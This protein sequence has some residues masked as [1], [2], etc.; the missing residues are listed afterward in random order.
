MIEVFYYPQCP[1]VAPVLLN[2]RDIARELGVDYRERDLFR[3][4]L[5][6]CRTSLLVAVD[7]RAV[8]IVVGT[9]DREYTKSVVEAALHGASVSRPA[10]AEDE[11]VSK[12]KRDSGETLKLLEAVAIGSSTIDDV[13]DLCISEDFIYGSLAEGY[14]DAAKKM[15][16]EWLERA[17]QR[18]GFAGMI[19]Y[20][21][22]RAV[23]FIEA[24]PGGISEN[25]GMTMAHHPEKTWE[26]LC[27][28]VMRRYWRA[29]VASLLVEKAM[30]HLKE[31]AQWVEVTARK[32][33]YWHPSDFYRSRGFE[34]AK[35]SGNRCIMSRFV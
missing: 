8:P 24:V 30:G 17:I 25:M 29:G 6:E 4:P 5:P 34:V 12:A 22:G 27:L 13:V 21:D 35:D 28:S 26:I 3:S 15:R 9:T 23:G 18:C 31:R 11:V 2:L 20:G 33:G 7:G 1:W 19:A 14:V 16:K 32:G 10:F